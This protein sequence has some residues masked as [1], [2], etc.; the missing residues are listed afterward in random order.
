MNLRLDAIDAGKD[1]TSSEWIHP[2]RENWRTQQ[3]NINQGTQMSKIKKEQ[4][5]NKFKARTTH[6]DTKSNNDDDTN[7]GHHFQEYKSKIT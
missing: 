7:D 2:A 4:Y 3:N 1:G 6:L 5:Y